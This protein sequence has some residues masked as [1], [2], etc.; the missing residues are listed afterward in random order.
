MSQDG[1]RSV[2]RDKIVRFDYLQLQSNSVRVSDDCPYQDWI[3]KFLVSSIDH[4]TSTTMMCCHLVM[5]LIEY[6]GPVELVVDGAVVC[7]GM[8][9][10]QL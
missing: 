7:L 9:I 5:R 10:H 4:K 2:P 8:P 6:V 3:A 1:T